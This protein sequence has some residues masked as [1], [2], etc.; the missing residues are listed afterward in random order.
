MFS[1][2]LSPGLQTMQ[3]PKRSPCVAHTHTVYIQTQTQTDNHKTAC[4]IVE[5]Q[6]RV[7]EVIEFPHDI[8]SSYMPVPIIGKCSPN[9]SSFESNYIGVP[10]KWHINLNTLHII[11][12][13][14]VAKCN[15]IFI[16]CEHSIL[17]RCQSPWRRLQLLWPQLCRS[18]CSVLPVCWYHSS[19][20]HSLKYQRTHNWRNSVKYILSFLPLT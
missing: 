13:W 6:L 5:G 3:L 8:S 1:S 2:P 18:G 20:L 16:L 17:E 7:P 9:T 4:P 12:D 10:I 14:Y 11:Y 15:N 19:Q